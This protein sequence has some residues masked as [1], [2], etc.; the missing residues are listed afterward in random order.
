M[1][2]ITTSP[3]QLSDY[4]LAMQ[5]PLVDAILFLQPTI[6]PDAQAI[7]QNMIQSQPCPISSLSRQPASG[8]V[9]GPDK[10]FPI[11]LLKCPGAAFTSFCKVYHIHPNI[12]KAL[13]DARRRKINRKWKRVSRC[14]C[15]HAAHKPADHESD[16]EGECATIDEAAVFAQLMAT[17]EGM[18]LPDA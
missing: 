13:G 1:T 15:M 3:H 7:A 10:L 16:S 4:M 12:V 6:G 14:K 8:S 2:E 18:D 17:S 11:P 9:N 5:M